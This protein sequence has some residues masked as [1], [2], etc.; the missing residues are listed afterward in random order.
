MR[1]SARNALRGVFG[2][3]VVVGLGFGASQALAAPVAAQAAN[4]CSRTHASMCN[5]D[6]RAQYGP[7]YGGRCY[8]DGV[9]GYT[10]ECFPFILP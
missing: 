1:H 6:C 4:S 3:L 2:G 10:C 9:G 7:G 8:A 5:A